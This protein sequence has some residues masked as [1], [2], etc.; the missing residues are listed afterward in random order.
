MLAAIL[1]SGLFS[2]APADTVRLLAWGWDDHGLALEVDT[3]TAAVL[4]TKA[5]GAQAPVVLD[6]D[7]GTY[8]RYS[9]PVDG[10]DGVK[11]G[12]AWRVMGAG[13]EQR[14]TVSSIDMIVS[15]HTGPGEWDDWGAPC[16]APLVLAALDCGGDEVPFGSIAVPA[17]NSRAQAGA[18]VGAQ[19]NIALPLG[20]AA[21]MLRQAPI[22]AL[23]AQSATEA[24]AASAGVVRTDVTRQR[25]TLGERA[26]DVYQ[27]RFYTGEGLDECGG[28]DM[29]HEWVGLAEGDTLFGA[30]SLLDGGI[31]GIFD[32]DGDGDIETL[33]HTRGLVTLRGADGAVLRT[34]AA[35]WCVCGC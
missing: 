7:G 4:V 18:Q 13:G 11:V 14:C 29:V 32:I 19:E 23:R 30:R 35:E 26:V 9:L 27:G 20:T 25:Y 8:H 34:H 22:K 33:E 31:Q 28:E 12:S 21:A 17:R 24:Q 10:L 5:R 15:P 3:K 1:F 2:S 16:A 6:T